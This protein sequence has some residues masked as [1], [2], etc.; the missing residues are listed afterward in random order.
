[1]ATGT[2]AF[3]QTI[4]QYLDK[5]AQEDELFARHYAKNEK[6]LKGCCSYIIETVEK[7][8]RNGF[9][10][11]E[12][13]GMAVHYY[14]EDDIKTNAYP[15]NLN[16]VVNHTIEL[17]EEEKAQAITKA[18]QDKIDELI[19]QEKAKLVKEALDGFRVELTP[20]DI[21]AAKQK[22][23]EEKIEEVKKAQKEKLA[24]KSEQKKKDAPAQPQIGEQATLF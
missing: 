12:I 1:M 20:E 18:K 10:D 11:E 15:A 19:R 22:A 23:L 8:K 24:K 6:T 13:F 4:K 2:D 9:A 21:E 14:Q 16:V 5:R 17:T 7:T 3:E